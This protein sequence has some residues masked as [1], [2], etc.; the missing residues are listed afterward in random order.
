MAGLVPAIPIKRHD[1]AFLSG[2]PGAKPGLTS[3]KDED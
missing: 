3:G 2:M 1:G